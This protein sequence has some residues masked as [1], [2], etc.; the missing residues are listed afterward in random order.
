M[1]E[2]IVRGHQGER[3]GPGEDKV[4]VRGWGELQENPGW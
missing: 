4:A 2:M 1:A 3:M